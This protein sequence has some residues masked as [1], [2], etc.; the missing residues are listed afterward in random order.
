MTGGNL[1]KRVERGKK[2]STQVGVAALFDSFDGL[3]GFLLSNCVH[4]GQGQL[5]VNL[6]MFHITMTARRG[7]R[8]KPTS[9]SKVAR[10]S[11]SSDLSCFMTNLS[12]SFS[13]AKWSFMLPLCRRYAYT[14]I[15]SCLLQVGAKPSVDG[16][17]YGNR[18]PQFLALQT[19]GLHFGHQRHLCSLP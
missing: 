13:K 10:N 2:T 8:G 19:L 4:A 1:V 16:G 17:T 15:A 3:F 5:D 12:V 14:S 9:W 11:L 6:P 7:F 18:S